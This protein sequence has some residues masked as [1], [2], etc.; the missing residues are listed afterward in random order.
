MAEERRRDFLLYIDEFQTFLGIRGP[1]ADALAQA[2][3]LHLSLTIANQHLGQ[4]PRELQEA[5]RSNAQSRVIFRCAEA[6]ASSLAREFA[7]LDA[8]ALLS[9]PRFVAAARLAAGGRAPRV[10]RL[11]TLR[12]AGTPADAVTAAEVLA[13]SGARFG[14]DAAAVDAAMRGVA[15]AGRAHH[16]HDGAASVDVP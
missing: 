11:R 16:R 10:V 13:A 9:L 12:P 8:T 1:F 4:L 2:R 14:R 3:G 5:V 6:D 7:P 15:L